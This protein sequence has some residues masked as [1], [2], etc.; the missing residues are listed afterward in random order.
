MKN[1]IIENERALRETRKNFLIQKNYIVD[2]A[3]DCHSAMTQISVCIYNLDMGADDYL[4]KP[5]HLAVS[6]RGE[7]VDQ[8]DNLNF[9]YSQVKNL[10]RKMKVLHVVPTLKAVYD[11]VYKLISQ[12]KKQ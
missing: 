2:V 3:A 1:L 5:F 9:I 11:F 4:A 10:R 7:R 6:A 12:G 8:A